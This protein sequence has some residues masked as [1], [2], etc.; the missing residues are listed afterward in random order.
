[1]K[2][3]EERQKKDQ[4][5]QQKKEQEQMRK[6]SQAEKKK[7]TTIEIN[8]DTHIDPKLIQ[9]WKKFDSI[10]SGL[11]FSKDTDTS[12]VTETHEITSPGSKWNQQPAHF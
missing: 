5:E 10:I 2:E 12:K 4:E 6:E 3:K 11:E 1:M 7:Q 8:I 9:E